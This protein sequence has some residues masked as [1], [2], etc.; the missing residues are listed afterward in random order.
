MFLCSG[1]HLSSSKAYSKVWD[2]IVND[3][4]QF[5]LD[6]SKA[7]K[8]VQQ[9][10]IDRK[11]IEAFR[12]IDTTAISNT[13]KRRRKTKASS[14]SN[15]L[16]RYVIRQ[17]KG[18]PPAQNSSEMAYAESLTYLFELYR[19]AAVCCTNLNC[20]DDKWDAHSKTRDW[21][22]CLFVFRMSMRQSWR[23]LC[24]DGHGKVEALFAHVL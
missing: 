24:R 17:D 20:T 19:E 3:E 13:P 2:E 10:A 16:F 7:V 12:E 1:F 23:K 9:R 22:T 4:F 15:Q 11:W 6:L 5:L 18:E 21:M 14:D 8:K